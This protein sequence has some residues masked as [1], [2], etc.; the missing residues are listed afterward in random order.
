MKIVISKS[1]RPEKKF[2]AEIA[3]KTVHFGAKGYSDYT[4]HRDDDRKNNYIARHRSNEDWT[5]SGMKSA[6]FYAKH[7]LWNKKSFRESLNDLNN[8]FKNVTFVYK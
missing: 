2:Q 7:L 3:K 6:G 1:S 5:A 8:Q 4:Q